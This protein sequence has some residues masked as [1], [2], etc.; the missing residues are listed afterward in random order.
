MERFLATSSKRYAPL[1]LHLVWP[2]SQTVQNSP[3]IYLCHFRKHCTFVITKRKLEAVCSINSLSQ[4]DFRQ[5]V[6]L[7]FVSVS[8]SVN[9]IW[10]S[11][12]ERDYH[13]GKVFQFILLYLRKT[14]ATFFIWTGISLQFNWKSS[15][16]K[17][18]CQSKQVTT[19]VLKVAHLLHYSSPMPGSVLEVVWFSCS[20]IVCFHTNG[21]VF[22]QFLLFLK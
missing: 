4:S 16:L 5:V 20:P 19:E 18:E 12:D 14:A 21:Y 17:R 1:D 10:K 15:T 8:P 3:W 13:P 6:E 2:T 7:V 22:I 11:F 9:I